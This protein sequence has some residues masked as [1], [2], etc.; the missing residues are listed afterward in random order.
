MRVV[1]HAPLELTA[2]LDEGDRQL[3]VRRQDLGSSAVRLIE[4]AG[5]SEP[6]LA[7]ASIA[8]TMPT[9]LVRPLRV[10]ETCCSPLV[11]RASKG[12][13]T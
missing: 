12:F 8:V 10:R 13:A 7:I 6:L 1:A 5:L 11:G 2:V 9:C 4:P 3:R